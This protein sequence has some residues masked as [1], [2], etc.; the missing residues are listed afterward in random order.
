MTGDNSSKLAA[1]RVGK[2]FVSKHVTDLDQ[3]F[4]LCGHDAMVF[5]L[6]GALEAL[7]ADVSS[8]TWEK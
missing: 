7:G 3:R 1:E 2:A 4:Y 6:R 5:D 8:V